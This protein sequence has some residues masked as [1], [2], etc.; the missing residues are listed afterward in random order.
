MKIK[1]KRIRD[2]F[3]FMHFNP[4]LYVIDKWICLS[5]VGIHL[6]ITIV[7]W[8]KANIVFFVRHISS[9]FNVQWAQL[10]W[11]VIVRVVDIGGIDD[12]HRLN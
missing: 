4:K 12:N 5:R 11:E 3:F 2:I 6:V 10:R 8:F 9:S 1:K 7:E